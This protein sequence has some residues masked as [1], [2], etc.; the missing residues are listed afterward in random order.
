MKS[1][2]FGLR[3]VLIALLFSGIA[4]AAESN[5][6]IVKGKKVV[7]TVNGEPITL[8]EYNRGV[9]SLPAADAG[10]K[11]DLL[12]RLINSQLIVQEG[13]RAGLDELSEIKQRVDVFSRVTLRDELMARQ[14]KNI[15]PD[16]KEVEKLYKDSVKEVKLT[17][18]LFEKEDVAN[19]MQKAITEG[20]NFDEMLKTFVA[21]GTAKESEVGKYLKNRELL[22]EI[23]AAIGKMKVGEVSPVIRLK[24]GFVVLRLE[25]LRYPEDKEAKE[26]A[27]QEALKHKQKEVLGKYDD[28]L[29]KKYAKVNQKVLDQ[30]DF[31][32]KEPGFQNLS[33]DQRIVAEIKG[34]KPITVGE[35]TDHIRQQLYHGVERAIESKRIN[36]KKGQVLDEMIHKRAF[37]KEAL[38]LGIDKT[39]SY[40]A[41]VREH[42][43]SL[44]FGAYVQKAVVPEVKLQEKELESYYNEH[45]NDF[46]Y[47]EMMKIESLAFK[48]RKNAEEAIENLR[49]GAE[50]RWVKDHAEG[51]MDKN[52]EGVMNFEG[53]LLTVKDFSE[54]LQKA[55]SGARSG[56]Y[57]LYGSST[58]HFYVLAIQEV[59]PSKPQP[60]TEV[61]GEVAKKVYNEK[62][63]KAIEDLADKLRALSDVKIY[64]KE[65]N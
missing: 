27:K 61:R 40:K 60:Y 39:G 17:S 65:K 45:I 49:K 32:S 55:V 1:F 30:L 29:R 51:Q 57:K 23:A 34:E 33:K 59:V 31:E 24:T 7:A 63:K 56:D 64:L 53:K 36:K 2:T 44:V 41:K 47:P 9:L 35:L 4:A 11:E 20:K 21:D 25:G 5:L 6:P 50:L 43:D 10:K 58:G 48:Q 42:E 18:V 28:G 22:P 46:T 16:P 54:D 26:Q 37:M 19:K 38:R 13:K 62:L 12:R 3:M 14:V 52:A 15:K 8:E